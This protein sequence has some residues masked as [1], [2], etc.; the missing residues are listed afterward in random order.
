MIVFMH[1]CAPTY[2]YTCTGIIVWRAF[3]P[4]GPS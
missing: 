2:M 4:R 3:M 1:V